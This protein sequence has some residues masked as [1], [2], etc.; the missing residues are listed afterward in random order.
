MMG[1]GFIFHPHHIKDGD[2]FHS[3]LNPVLDTSGGGF[4]YS[5]LAAFGKAASLTDFKN[6]KSADSFRCPR[7]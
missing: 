4:C 7:F 2:P 1:C 6:K 5:T 3:F